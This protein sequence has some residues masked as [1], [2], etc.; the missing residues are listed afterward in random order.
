MI[1]S[2]FKKLGELMFGRKITLEWLL[3]ALK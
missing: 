1:I 2:Y 3:G